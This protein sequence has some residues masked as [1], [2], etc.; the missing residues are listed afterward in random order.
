MDTINI[1]RIL[2]RHTWIVLI[3][4]MAVFL[5]F[6][7]A[8][9]AEQSI[10]VADI[11]LGTVGENEFN[12]G[13]AFIPSHAIFWES[14]ISWRITISSYDPDL[15]MS[16]D[17]TYI[18]PLSDLLWKLSDEETWLPVTQE[19]EELEWGTETGDGVIYVDFAVLLAWM[20]D[21]PGQYGTELIFTIESL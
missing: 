14:D 8:V 9:R 11:N 16:D 4:A 1:Y 6:S 13:Y 2:R 5:V 10:N 21:V 3:I 12:D 7:P 19:E 20:K 18:K 17:G 15:G